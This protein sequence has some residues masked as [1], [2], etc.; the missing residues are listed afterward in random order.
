MG[1]IMQTII[2]TSKQLAT[3][4]KARRKALRLTQKEVAVLVGLLPKTVSSLETDPDRCS[5]ESL[6]MLLSAL[7]LELT[8]SP[9]D[10]GAS[11]VREAEW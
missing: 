5:V 6:R 11:A 4:L 8:L 2:F 3:M 9:E 10:E 7:K 1:D